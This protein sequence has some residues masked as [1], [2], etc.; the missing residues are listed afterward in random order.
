MKYPKKAKVLNLDLEWSDIEQSYFNVYPGKVGTIRK[1]I[2]DVEIRNGILVCSSN[3]H[4]Y[5]SNYE[6]SGKDMYIEGQ[7][8]IG[9]IERRKEICEFFLDK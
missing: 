3:G 7:A 1:I 9:I 4:G 8:V 5:I 6:N 2:I